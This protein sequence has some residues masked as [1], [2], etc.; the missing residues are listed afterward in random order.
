MKSVQHHHHEILQ[1]QTSIIK[2]S[3][4]FGGDFLKEREG[5]EVTLATKIARKTQKRY[6]KRE[7]N[8]RVNRW[9]QHQ[10]AGRFQELK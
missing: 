1:Q 3:E 8:L 5:N 7:E 10:R 4:N 6:S 2:L 9:R